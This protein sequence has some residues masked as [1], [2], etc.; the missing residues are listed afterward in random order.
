[1]FLVVSSI[2]VKTAAGYS[3]AVKTAQDLANETNEKARIFKMP[4]TVEFVACPSK[5]PKQ[6]LQTHQTDKKQRRK[7]ISN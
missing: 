7:K 5:Q 6:E 4:S 3:A 1:M 2:G